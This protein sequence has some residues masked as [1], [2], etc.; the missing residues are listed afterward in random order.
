[1]WLRT[2][3]YYELGTLDAANEYTPMI[4]SKDFRTAVFTVIA[5]DSA[6]AT[7]KFYWSNSET[8]PTL[9]SAASTTNEYDEAQVINLDTHA[10]V[11]GSTGVVFAWS[12]DGITRYEL[13]EN[14]NNWIGVKMTARSA[15]SVTIKV[16]LYDNQ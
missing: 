14:G 9:W 13:N 10:W 2:T 7:I 1:M 16:D 4:F 12:S 6:N 15:G 5:A 11:D 8:R 3:A